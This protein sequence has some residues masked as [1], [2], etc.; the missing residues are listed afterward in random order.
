[1]A[2]APGGT[3]VTFLDESLLGLI[4]SLVPSTERSEGSAC[5]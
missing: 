2:M 1:M 3:T 4:F 5:D